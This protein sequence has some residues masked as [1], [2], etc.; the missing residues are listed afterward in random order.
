VK[1]SDTTL[2]LDKPLPYCPGCGHGIINR[3]LSEVISELD[4]GGNAVGVIGIGCYTILHQYLQIDTFC[5]LHGRAVAVATGLKRSRPQ[6]IVFTYQGDGDC[7][8]IG[9][10]ELVHAAGRNENITVIM[11]NNGVYGMTGGQ[12]SPTTLMGQKTVTSPLGRELS[13]G[14]PLHVSEMLS[15]IDMAQYVTR[16]AVNT[17]A[18]VRKAKQSM[19]QAFK[20]QINGQGFSFL[21]IVSPCPTHLRMAPTDAADWVEKMILSEY[22]PRVFR[23][24][25]RQ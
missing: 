3:I 14:A 12:M 16:V 9:M 5:A 11:V 2:W 23:T 20:T 6:N 4:I 24:K 21:E 22:E 1:P 19:T 25:K 13:H 8:A 15:T 10:G 7:A 18:H 17:P